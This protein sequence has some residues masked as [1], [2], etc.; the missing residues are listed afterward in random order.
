MRT[1]IRATPAICSRAYDEQGA[2]IELLSSPRPQGARCCRH[3]APV[4]E[5][6]SLTEANCWRT[7]ALYEKVNMAGGSGAWH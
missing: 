1:D 6:M 7:K 2:Q 3:P 5:I 4:V